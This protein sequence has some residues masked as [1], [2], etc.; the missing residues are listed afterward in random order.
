MSETLVL[1]LAPLRIEQLALRGETGL[2]V[3]H[4]GM[5]PV[6]ARR[7]AAAA[8]ASAAPAVAVAGLCAGIAPHLRAGD[9]VCATELLPDGGDP[10]AVPAGD[11]LAAALRRHGLCVHVGALA[12]SARVESAGERRARAG[13]ALVLD[14]ESAW[15]AAGAGGR[16]FAVLRVVVDAD[17]RSLADLRIALAGV[18]ALRSL[19]RSRGALVEWATA[20]VAG[21]PALPTLPTPAGGGG[22]GVEPSTGRNGELALGG[23]H[24]IGH[25]AIMAVPGHASTAPAASERGRPFA[26][27]AVGSAGAERFERA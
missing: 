27:R 1:V 6:R 11:R 23:Q 22:H 2:E 25:N 12:S 7:A 26:L 3:L 5:G 14:M 13:S 4:A 15:L 18:R 19:R 24:R 20:A 10:I 21:T 16:P 9:V 8:L 17:G